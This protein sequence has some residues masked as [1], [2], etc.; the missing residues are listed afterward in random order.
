MAVQYASFWRRV[1]A[2]L[3][4]SLVVNVGTFVL[5]SV[6]GAAGFSAG[7]TEEGASAAAFVLG[8][9]FSPAYSVLFTGLVGQTPG[10]MAVGIRVVLADGRV[11]GVGRAFLREVVGKFL[12]G[13]V[14]CVG[15]L[16]MLWDAERQCWH[17]KL[18]GTRV[19]RVAQAAPVSPAAGVC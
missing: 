3:I 19:V 2:T 13:L 11:P 12:S 9:L 14:L 5:G 7:M 18:A 8:V 16:W 6:V 17:D 4:D 1:A 10:K 15:Y